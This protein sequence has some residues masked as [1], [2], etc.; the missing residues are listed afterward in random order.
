MTYLI[1]MITPPSGLVLDPFCGSGTT[2]V[3]AG[4]SGFDFIGIEKDP[5]YAN[6]ASHR[7]QHEMLLSDEATQNLEGDDLDDHDQ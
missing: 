1:T 7:F 3:S 2:G 5:T 6:I 4:R